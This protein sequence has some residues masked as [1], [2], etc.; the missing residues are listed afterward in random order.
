MGQPIDPTRTI[1]TQDYM[2]LLGFGSSTPE[3][4]F[5]DKV[6]PSLM[7]NSTRIPPEVRS[8]FVQVPAA[9]PVII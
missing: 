9:Q 1:Y 5:K 4:L 2:A 6:M 3:E 8:L 7:K